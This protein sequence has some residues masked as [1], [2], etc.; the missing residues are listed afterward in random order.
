MGCVVSVYHGYRPG[1]G[2]VHR[3]PIGQANSPG[4]HSDSAVPFVQGTSIRLRHSD[5]FSPS[6]PS[7]S[8]GILTASRVF[9]RALMTAQVVLH[10]SIFCLLWQVRIPAF[11][12]RATH[13]LCLTF[14]G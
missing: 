8:C 3:R 9:S 2:A 1:H 6:F 5:G 10:L 14:A 7:I 12:K 11:R 4:W 13:G